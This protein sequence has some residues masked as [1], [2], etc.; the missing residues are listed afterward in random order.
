MSME[1][2]KS[3][4][5]WAFLAILAIGTL[6]NSKPFFADFFADTGAGNPTQEA[7]RHKLKRESES[8]SSLKFELVDPEEAPEKMRDLVVLGY[9]IMLETPKYAKG[10]V[11]ELTE[12]S[13]TNCHFAGGNTTGGK[14]GGISLAGVAAKYPHYDDRVKKVIDLPTRI[15]YCFEKSLNG[16]A[17]PLDSKEMLAL[18]SYLHNISSHFPLYDNVPW[19]GLKRL[20]SSHQSDPA[21]GQR[22][23][24]ASCAMCHGNDGQGQR[25][26]DDPT[27]NVPPLWGE[28]SFNAAAGMNS[29]KTL[30]SFIYENMPYTDAGLT[31][32]Q[33]I[34][35]AAFIIGKPHP[36]H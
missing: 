31:V 17:L 23:Y 10:Y 19:L 21:A 15:N 25:Y 1:F 6:W 28:H 30:E 14:N 3:P 16:K 12:L 36:G 9:H 13:C 35:V 34:D 33:A 5:V 18:V 11:G 4:F 24:E 29:Q 22:V 26:Q 8:F 27:A 2:K 32:E 7:I 20:E